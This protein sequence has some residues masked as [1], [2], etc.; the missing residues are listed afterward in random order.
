MLFE[1]T[2]ECEVAF[3]RL[4][5]AITTPPVLVYPLPNG[6][7]FILD[8]DASGVGMG[9]VLAQL[10]EQE[11][12]VIAY[13]SKVFSETERRYCTTHQEL[14]AGRYYEGYF[15]PYLQGLRFRLRTDYGALR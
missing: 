10:Q 15:K 12:K 14:L 4:K 9:A 1:W 6:G 3:Q 13:A 7:I 5:E 11:E 8:T 2:V